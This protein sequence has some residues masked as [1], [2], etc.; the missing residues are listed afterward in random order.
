[1]VVSQ[2]RL[3]HDFLVLKLTVVEVSP[4]MIALARQR[5]GANAGRFRRHCLDLLSWE[6]EGSYDAIVTCFFLN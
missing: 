3:L 4:R 2:T 6:T 1:M 5:I